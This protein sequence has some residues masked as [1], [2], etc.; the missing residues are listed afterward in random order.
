MIYL[1]KI[2]EEKNVTANEIADALNM[3]RQTIWAYERG[4]RNPDP[5]TLCAIA[6]LL[7]VSLDMLIRGK[8]KD[9][10]Q[11]RSI[12]ELLTIFR[13]LSDEQLDYFITV[14]QA[15]KA[16]RRFQAHLRQDE[17]EDQ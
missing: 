4:E 13:E 10:L 7:N 9:R 16:D 8:E 5:E 15:V 14:M 17:K 11:G 2:R 6:D 3:S 12:E 1:K